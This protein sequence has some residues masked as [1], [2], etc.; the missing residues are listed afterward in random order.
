MANRNLVYGVIAVI[1]VVLLIWMFAGR[2]EPVTTTAPAPAATTAAP[3]TPAPAP[4][5]STT[6]PAGGTT[7]TPPAGGTTA[8]AQ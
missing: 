7:T 6:P 3:A 2:D 1:V 8:P 4:T 5:E